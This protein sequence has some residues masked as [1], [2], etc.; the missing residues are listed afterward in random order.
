[1]GIYVMGQPG[2]WWEYTA[3]ASI[4]IAILALF[5]NV[6]LWSELSNLV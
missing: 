5:G 3:V 1:M 4:K 6:L 2:A